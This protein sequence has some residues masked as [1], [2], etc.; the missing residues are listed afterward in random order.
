[1]CFSA[2]ASFIAGGGLAAAGVATVTQAKTRSRLPLAAMPLLFGIQQITEGV[3]WSSSG[4]PWLQGAAAYVYIL[5]AYVLWPTYL[6][7]AVMALEKPG[8]RKTVLKWLVVFGAAVSMWLLYY[9]VQGPITVA[10]TSHGCQYGVNVPRVPY[11]IAAYVFVTCF[12]CFISSHKFVRWFGAALIGALAIA[13]WSYREAFY[14][15]WCFFAAILSLIIF[16]HLTQT[17]AEIGQLVQK[18]EKAVGKRLPGAHP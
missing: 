13:L 15:V 18:A 11:G 8:R 3:V 6:P 17:K 4:I 1:M 10:L 2:T 7:V 5:F 12:T 16:V 9:L 14:S